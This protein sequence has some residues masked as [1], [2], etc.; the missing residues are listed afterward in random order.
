M[1]SNRCSALQRVLRGPP[2]EGPSSTRSTL[3]H[4]LPSRV[5]ILYQIPIDIPHLLNEFIWGWPDH[6][7]DSTVDLRGVVG[8]RVYLSK[9]FHRDS[10]SGAG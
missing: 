4:L 1:L 9:G 8:D 5:L 10:A 2:H 3:S 7:F 6:E